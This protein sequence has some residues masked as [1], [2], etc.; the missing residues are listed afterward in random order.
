MTFKVFL[1]IEYYEYAFVRLFLRFSIEVLCTFCANMY[2][3]YAEV[4]FYGH[5]GV[6]CLWDFQSIFAFKMP[7]RIP[8]EV[9]LGDE[10]PE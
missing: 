10:T 9:Y 2:A 4:I 5:P 1:E 3:R 6:R 7:L 8:Q